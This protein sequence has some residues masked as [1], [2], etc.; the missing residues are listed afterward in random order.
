[1]SAGSKCML[2]DKNGAELLEWA[3]L[4]LVLL[5]ATAGVVLTMRSLVGD[6]FI[7]IL[8]ELAAP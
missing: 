2:K 8:N 1:M 7:N 6:I 5:L 3:V 4:T